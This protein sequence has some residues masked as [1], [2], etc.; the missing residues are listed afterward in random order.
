[1]NGPGTLEITAQ[2]RV[3]GAAAAAYVCPSCKGPLS[4]SEC[5]G[6]GARYEVG[7]DVSNFFTSSPVA[8]RYRRIA[9]F[10]D[11]LYQEKE[12]AWKSLAGRGEEFRRFMASLVGASRPKRYLDL[13]CGAGYLLAAVSAEEKQGVEISARALGAARDR[14]GARLCLAVAEELPFDRGYFD[15]VTGIG[16]TEHLVD[17]VMATSEVHRVLRPGGQYI[18]LLY[19]PTPW[20]ERI[21]VKVSEFLYPS[22]RGLKLVRWLFGKSAAVFAGGAE[23]RREDGVAQPVQPVQNKYTPRSARRLFDRCGF[24]VKQVITKRHPLGTVLAGHDSRIYL[25]EK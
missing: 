14:A 5:L 15:V 18:A 1:M 10:Y 2:T 20:T 9:C 8:E 23:G 3:E 7:E 17:A 25:L 22:F 12:D 6:C 11:D 24:R 21:A 13:G 4:G 16:V 19:M